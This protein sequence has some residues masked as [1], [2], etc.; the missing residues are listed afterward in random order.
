[1]LGKYTPT[2]RYGHSQ[3][4]LDEQNLLIIGGSGGQSYYFSDAWVLNLIGDI[5]MWKKV[6]VRNKSH[7]PINLWC[8]PVCKVS[9]L[10]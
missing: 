7:A 6:E 4:V 1:M 3:V 8:N 5:W 2:E 10:K 9:F